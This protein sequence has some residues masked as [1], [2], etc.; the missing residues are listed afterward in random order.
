MFNQLPST[1][2]N[3][4]LRTTACVLPAAIALVL[5]V[6]VGL[7]AVDAQVENEAGPMD[8][9][10]RSLTTSEFSICPTELADCYYTDDESCRECVNVVS[11]GTASCD[12]DGVSSCSD[13]QDFYCCALEGEG[14]DCA[15]NHVFA[16]YIGR[17]LDGF[18]YGEAL[19]SYAGEGCLVERGQVNCQRP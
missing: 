1:R 15:D 16:S 19:L 14:E 18:L 12:E 3:I 4:A 11:E 7:V 9:M 10:R 13:V 17:F 5:V 6:F 8:I 2:L